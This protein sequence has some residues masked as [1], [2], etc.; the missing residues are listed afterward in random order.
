M[1]SSAKAVLKQSK[2]LF[3]SKEMVESAF[4]KEI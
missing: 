2:A 4:S 3:N 1:G